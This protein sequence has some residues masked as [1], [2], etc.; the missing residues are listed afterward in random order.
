M[1][2]CDPPSQRPH[3]QVHGNVHGTLAQ[4]DA[5]QGDLILH[6]PTPPGPR[7]P[8]P[9]QLPLAPAVH[10][11]HTAAL[12]RMGAA[13]E[14]AHARGRS[15]LI[16]LTGPAGIGKTALATRFL[17]QH[18]DLG[19]DGH[20]L[21]D[22]RG[23]ATAPAD[24]EEVLEFLLYS[25]GAPLG[26]SPR[27]PGACS[28]WWRS[29]TAPL[30]IAL[31][32]DDA[33]C[34]AAVRALL[35]AGA[36]STVVVTARRPLAELRVDG[37][38]ALTVPALGARDSLRVLTAVGQDHPT[39]TEDHRALE[40]IS[41]RCAGLPLAL[42]AVAARHSTHPRPWAHTAR[43]LN[44]ETPMNPLDPAYADLPPDTAHTYRHLA[45]HPGPDITGRAVAMLTHP[46][47]APHPEDLAELA[48]ARLLHE[49]AP[50]R[51]RLTDPDHARAAAQAG[52]TQAERRQAQA[53][54]VG[55]WAMLAAAADRALRPY[56]HEHPTDREAARQIFPDAAHANAW[57]FEERENLAALSALALE[58]SLV[59][60]AVRLVEGM[61]PMVLHQ[62]QD[63]L[64][65]RAARPALDALQD[66]APALRARLLQKCALALSHL[67]RDQEALTDLNEAELIWTDLD[68]RPRL[69]QTLQ[70][71]G[72]IAYEAGHPAEAVTHLERALAADEHTG[73]DHHRGITLFQ[74]GRALL[75]LGEVLP[76]RTRLEHALQLLQGD[77]YNSARARIALGEV[78]VRLDQH[79]PALQEL[80]AA[81]D[82]MVEHG[83]LSGQAQAMEGIGVFS[84]ACGHPDGARR[85]YNT[86]LE[87]L[88][89]LA[90][91]DPVRQRV[92]ARLDRMEAR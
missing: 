17:H 37:A 39:R 9:R 40:H 83:S 12:E 67:R 34:A 57:L 76:A 4:V 19:A 92:R 29:A 61:W 44:Q 53:L 24:P 91:A 60:E 20:L 6:A 10:V 55:G 36:R 26:S 33:P 89:L 62:G 63:H 21:A 80:N 69:A 73:A 71:R 74:L 5:V 3:H 68:D 50:G 88:E 28:A 46:G 78:L 54:F 59:G 70:R 42:C 51:Y 27:P 49:H 72:I 48:A 66:S 75:A 43:T 47:H 85:A 2:T 77:A 84:E 87:L 14:H 30:C 32:V 35:P 58:L 45:W 22:L 38:L 65:L 81:R 25:L 31:L 16:V 82:A 8:T 56:A 64:W 15:A 41:A 11:N 86:A 23:T 18:P 79:E 1:N 52:E 13:V 7:P 90:P